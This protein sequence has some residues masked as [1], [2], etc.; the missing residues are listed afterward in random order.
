M[1]WSSGWYVTK[2]L[3]ISWWTDIT[4]QGDLKDSAW[5]KMAVLDSQFIASSNADFA[6]IKAC[7]EP[8]II[9]QPF[10]WAKKG[11]ISLNLLLLLVGRSHE[12]ATAAR[13]C[14]GWSLSAIRVFSHLPAPYF[15]HFLLQDI[16]DLA[17]LRPFLVV[18]IPAALHQLFQPGG[19]FLSPTDAQCSCQT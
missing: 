10:P 13:A 7:S 6:Y 1:K 11:I 17:E 3:E 5:Q 16:A 15:F 8:L 14:L 4:I 12:W 19:Y 18:C 9:L 2:H